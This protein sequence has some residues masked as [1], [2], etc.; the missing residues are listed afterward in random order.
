MRIK[1]SLCV[2]MY[3]SAAP[4]MLIP[5]VAKTG[6]AAIEFWGWD[7]TLPEVIALAKKHSL[8]IASMSGP[9]IGLNDKANHARAQE[10]IPRSIDVAA[11]NGIP[12]LICFSGD[13][14]DGLTDAEGIEITAEGLKRLAPY[15][16]KKGVTLNL[17]LLNSKVDHKGYQADHTAWGVEVCKRVD[18]PSVRLL[19]DIYHMQIM[20]GDI[21]R[22]IQDNI[23]WIGHFHTAGNPGRNDFDDTQELNYQG[24]CKAI[25]QTS[26]RGYLAH[27][28]SPK[29]D[30]IE[31]LRKAFEICDQI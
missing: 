6:Y 10:E 25:A 8:A 18:S 28:F 30:V 24:I 27:E 20:E 26:Y 11:A 19:Y 13:R 17:E 31:S 12:G 23:Q 15:A 4:E 29:G 7:Q 1:Q 2:P 21:I 22:T 3:K 16:Q 14:R 5:A 9:W